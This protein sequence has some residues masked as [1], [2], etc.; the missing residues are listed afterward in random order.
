M[1]AGWRSSAIL[2]LLLAATTA[3]AAPLKL[4]DDAGRAVVMN[5]PAAHIVALSPHVTELKRRY[6]GRQPVRVFYEI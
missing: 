1:M 2:L 4:A 6:A 5:L 3:V